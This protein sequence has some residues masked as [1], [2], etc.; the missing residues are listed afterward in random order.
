MSPGKKKLIQFAIMGALIG[1]GLMVTGNAGAANQSGR[2]VNPFT[3]SVWEPSRT[4]MG[5]D[6]VSVRKAPVL[7]IGDAVILGS[8]NNTGW[9]GGHL[10]WYQLTNG[11]HAGDIVYVAEHLKSLAKAGTKVR[12]GQQI[13]TAIPGYP[14]TEWGW[15]NANGSPRAYPC[16]HEG[17]K[18]N[19]GKEMA[20]FMMSLGATVGDPPGKGANAPSGKLC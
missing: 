16:Y 5:V 4:D 11:S 9:P 3:S 8:Q 7:A 6:W 17:Q 20:R 10:I 12:A 2:Y 1:A 18:T 14:W 15:A 13:A 19:S